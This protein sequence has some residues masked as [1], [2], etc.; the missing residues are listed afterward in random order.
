[1]FW[2]AANAEECLYADNLDE[3]VSTMVDGQG[4][5]HFFP[6][7]FELQRAKQFP[8][9]KVTVTGLDENGEPQYTTRQP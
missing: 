5:P 4:L 2:D 6:I 7:E 9:I 8:N 1:M 3:A